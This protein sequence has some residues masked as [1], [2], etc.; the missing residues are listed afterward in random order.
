MQ[1]RHMS[2]L[3]A[4]A[5]RNLTATPLPNGLAI[6]ARRRRNDAHR[7]QDRVSPDQWRALGVVR[8]STRADGVADFCSDVYLPPPPAGSTGR[9]RKIEP[10][11]I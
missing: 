8:R 1:F 4:D 3:M 9:S 2:E 6:L 10:R 5:Y 7:N 11:G